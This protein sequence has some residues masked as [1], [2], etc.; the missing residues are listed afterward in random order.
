VR[1]LEGLPDR[2]GVLRGEAPPEQLWI[3]ENGLKFAVDLVHGQKTAS[4]STSAP[5]VNGSGSWQPAQR[6]ELFL[7]YR[8]FSLNLLQ[9]GAQD[10]LSVEP[11][12]KRSSWAGATWR[13]CDTGRAGRWLQGDRLQVLRGYATGA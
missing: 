11:R 9:G 8:C 7:L 6:A 10:V 12:P 2:T 1:Q 3:Q 13:Q 5:T 4:I